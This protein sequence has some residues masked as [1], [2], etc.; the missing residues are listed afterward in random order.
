MEYPGF[1]L[2]FEGG[3]GVGKST[4]AA[5]IA[6]WLRSDEGGF[7]VVTETREPGGT[8]LGAKIREA[9][10]HGDEVTAKA[11]ALLYAA[12]R[13]QHVSEVVLPAL[14]RGEAVVQDRYVDSSI[15]YQGVARGLGDQVALLSTWATDGLVPNLTVL[16]DMEPDPSRLGADLDRVERETLGK[17]QAIR[18]AFL[19]QAEK[20]PERYVVVDASKVA[21]AVH[22]DV[23]TAVAKRAPAKA[24][25]ATPPPPKPKTGDWT[26]WELSE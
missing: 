12:D 18:A 6:D 8:A 9:V 26:N 16:L 21:E 3:D 4:Q 15:A 22:L 10:M 23:R 20:D 14:Q 1:F 17:A 7:W 19:A 5:L 25:A 24:P 13:A 11:E 2:V